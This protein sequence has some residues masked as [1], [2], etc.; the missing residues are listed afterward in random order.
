MKTET[1]EAIVRYVRNCVIGLGVMP[2]YK[3]IKEWV[4]VN[5]DEDVTLEEIEAMEIPSEDKIYEIFIEEIDNIAREDATP[6]SDDVRD[7]RGSDS[8]DSS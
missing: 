6:P 8:T 5:E 1:A 7:I 3:Q 4:K 2:T